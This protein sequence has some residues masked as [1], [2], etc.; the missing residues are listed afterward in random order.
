MCPALYDSEPCG[1]R[2]RLAPE[3]H[4]CLNVK[5]AEGD[6]TEEAPVKEEPSGKLDST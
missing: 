6:P 4:S 1:F 5:P 2:S 3:H